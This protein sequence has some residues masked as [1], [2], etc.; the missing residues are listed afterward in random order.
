MAEDMERM[1][2][3]LSL[4]PERAHYAEQARSWREREARAREAEQRSKVSRSAP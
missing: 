1:A 4:A 2:H 3:V